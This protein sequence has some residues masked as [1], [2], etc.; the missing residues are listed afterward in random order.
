MARGATRCPS[1]CQKRN[2]RMGRWCSPISLRCWRNVSAILAV[3]V[4]PCGD[5][6]RSGILAITDARGVRT[7]KPER[8]VWKAAGR[9]GRRISLDVSS[10]WGLV[11]AHE[12]SSSMRCPRCQHENPSHQKFCGECGAR[13]TARCPDC[14]A[15]NPPG[16]KFCGECGTSLT[17][18]KA[19]RK[20]GSRCC[21][22]T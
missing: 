17:S 3:A 13:L 14:G 18:T 1:A 7:V 16:Q 2:R 20:F 8:G 10:R 15:S 4:V 12:R 19:D 21:S 9:A 22:P 6:G 5:P 11:L